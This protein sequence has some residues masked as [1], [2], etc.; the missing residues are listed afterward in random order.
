MPRSRPLSDRRR[1][2]CAD[3]CMARGRAP[4]GRAPHRH[5]QV[6]GSWVSSTVVRFSF[7]LQLYASAAGTVLVSTEVPV[8]APLPFDGL[9]F[10]PSFASSSNWPELRSLSVPQLV[11]VTSP[12]SGLVAFVIVMPVNANGS[13]SK[14]T[15]APNV[16]P[17]WVTIMPS[18]SVNESLTP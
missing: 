4:H 6:C 1:S 9:V 12:L 17:T 13:P 14:L 10:T 8:M 7:H 11:S 15:T 5:M 3:P 18:S 16:L 2:R